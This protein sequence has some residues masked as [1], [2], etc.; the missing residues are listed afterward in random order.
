MAYEFTVSDV[1]PATPTAIYDAWMSSAGHAAMTGAEAEIDA[2]VGG[3]FT[4][5][6]GYIMGRTLDLDP[7][8]RIVQAWRSSEFE[9]SDRDSEIE[10]LL[11]AVPEGTRISIRHYEIPEGQSGYEQG[12]RDNYFDPM[13]DYFSSIDA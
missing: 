2:R 10:V 9:P 1:L 7:G 5:W 8:R 3:D 6:D 11:E 13:R 4:A 12:W